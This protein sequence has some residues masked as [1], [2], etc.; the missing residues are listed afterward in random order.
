MIPPSEVRSKCKEPMDDELFDLMVQ[1][2]A[3]SV[4]DIKYD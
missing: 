2:Y 1:D 3:E 4:E